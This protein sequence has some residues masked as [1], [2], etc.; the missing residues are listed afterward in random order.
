MFEYAGVDWER[1]P[2]GPELA[3][4]LEQLDL[5]RLSGFGLVEVIRAS[6]RLRSWSVAVQYQAMAELAHCAEQA[7]P[8]SS[9]T[10]QARTVAVNE[11]AVDEAAAALRIAR[12][13]AGHRLGVALALTERLPA[14][15]AALR[16]GVIHEAQARVIC[17]HTAV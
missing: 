2:A 7:L 4:A 14:T 12:P 17:E 15:C 11:V 1:L 16:S 10:P 3:V 6:E 8:E 9:P 13:T 5:G